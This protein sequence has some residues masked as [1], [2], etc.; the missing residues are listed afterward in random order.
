M[1]QAD[2]LADD[3]VEIMIGG[4]VPSEVES[5]FIV[6]VQGAQGKK[7]MVLRN[8]RPIHT[9]IIE[10]DNFQLRFVEKPSGYNA[11]RVE[12][13]D[14]PNAEGFGELDVLAMTGAIYAQELLIIDPN[15]DP[16]SMWVKLDNESQ[17]PQFAERQKAPDGATFVRVTPSTAIPSDSGEFRPPEGDKVL[18]TIVPQW[19]Y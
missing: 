19:E 10:M 17:T 9:K 5:R 3:K 13:V 18:P 14:T 6:T 2:I 4:I 7:C 15:T 8:G 1:L 11:Y 16:T 12:V